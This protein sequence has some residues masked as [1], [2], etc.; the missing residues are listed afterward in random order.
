MPQYL[1]NILVVTKDEIIP[2]FWNCYNSLK[3]E[4]WRYKDK[5]YGI[6]RAMLGGNRR[7]LLVEFDS[8]PSEMQDA[9]GDPRK[10][11]H[12]LERYYKRDIEAVETYEK[13]QYPDGKYLLPQTKE[14]YIIN[15]SMLTAIVKLEAA[16]ESERIAKGGTLRGISDTLYS[17]AHSFNAILLK[18]YNYEHSLNSNL[19]RF[20]QQLKAFKDDGYR[21]LIKDADGNSKKNALKRNNKTD[22]FL[23]NLF[24]GRKHKPTATDIAKEYEAFLNGYI[25][26]VNEA[27]GELYNPK[28]FK[29]LSHST[30]SNYLRS[31]ESRIGTHSKRSGDR[32]KLMQ[33]FIPYETLER[34]SFAGS[35][36]SI[37]DRQPPF[38]Y[39]KG[40]RMWWYLGIDLASEA[41]T[42]W[43]Y[44]KTKEELILNFYR[45]LV[46][47]YYDWNVPLPDA[48]ECE[49]SLNSQFKDSF[50]MD[51]TM[52]QNVQVHP[53][54]ARS[55]RI[56][57]YYRDFRY[58]IEKEQEGW[59]A[60]PFALS[61]ANQSSSE[62]KVQ[63]PYEKLVQQC[64]GNI[65][66][67]NNMPNTKNKHTSRFEYFKNHQHPELKA[68]NYKS[69]MIHLG[70]KT[71]SSCKA[72]IIHLQKSEWLLGDDNEI[73]TGENLIRL[74]K[75]VEGKGIDIYW[76]D[77]NQGKVFKAM[78]YD[79]GRYICEILPKPIAS[80][81]PIEATESHR[82]A[83]E[84]LARYRNTVTA[85]M[86]MQKSA[87]DKVTVIDNRKKT[88]SDSFSIPGI[89][90]F[91]P[92]STPVEELADTQDEFVYTPKE[93][94]PLGLARTFL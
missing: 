2:R 80:K 91:T 17:D 65:I 92:R 53:N 50:L 19:R 57:R 55:K 29:P 78:I 22:M 5:P 28:D 23:N 24:A 26:V 46:R 32:Q 25:E 1:G 54:S 47:N 11:Q 8:L 77:D 44:G 41:I 12:I 30:V 73:C 16:R 84:I 69:F 61:E 89:T 51:G 59:I 82:E 48:L 75:N 27:T 18:K 38:E 20:K 66:T 86:Q 37:D 15:A 72:G 6:K 67:W 31:Y 7:Q 76:L 70:Y 94:K 87:I 79:N 13:F 45:Q 71:E 35:M 56:E 62:K 68:T 34:P 33:A 4:L 88:I 64:F 42:A 21:S 74:L 93:N 90:S 60:R 14:K 49:S 63:I 81:A 52:F 36:I 3:S 83:R 10:P 39:D 43:A 40:K 9:I 85:Y 58:S